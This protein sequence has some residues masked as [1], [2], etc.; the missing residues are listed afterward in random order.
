MNRGSNT[1]TTLVN[2][3]RPWPPERLAQVYLDAGEPLAEVCPQFRR[4]DPRGPVLMRWARQAWSWP[5]ARP[6]SRVAPDPV[7][8]EAADI[9]RWTKLGRRLRFAARA[10]ADLAPLTIPRTLWGWLD[11]YQPQLVYSVLGS[12]QV[13]RLALRVAQRF[14]IPIVPHFMDDWPTT[15]YQDGLFTGV[16]R[17]VLLRHIQAVFRR[18]PTGLAISAVMAEEYRQRYGL[19]FETF[20][21]T[22]DTQL[23]G[24]ARPTRPPGP[25]AQLV[26]VGGLHLGRWELLRDLGQAAQ[27]LGERGQAAEVVVYAPATDLSEYGVRLLEHGGVRLGGTLASHEMPAVLRGADVLLHVESF[28][29]KLQRYTRLSLSTKLPQYLA[30]GRP[31]LAYAPAHLASCQ[32][33]EQCH[34]G[35]AVGVRDPARLRAAL[36][37]LLQDCELRERL[38]A[39]AWRAARNRHDIHSERER[40]RAVLADAALRYD[41]A[42]T[43]AMERRAA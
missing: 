25:A 1:G 29:P 19:A 17:W 3:F 8:C 9:G 20:M 40:F 7:L 14:Q 13:M 18:A 31:I 12:V 35:L 27:E 28:D 2:L 26:Y 11:D 24:G 5:S 21:N 37:R 22:V 42:A 6:K 32:H 16:P 23:F 41:T 34:S 4:L 10:W 38:G 36:Q 39:A 15:Q 30:A 43:P 33:V